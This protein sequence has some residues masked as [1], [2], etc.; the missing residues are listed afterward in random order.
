M[1]DAAIQGQFNFPTA[2]RI[3]AGCI[4]ELPSACR[5]L[6]I[7][8]P[9]VVTDAGISTLDWFAEI[10][11][12]LKRAALDFQVFS[13]IDANPSTHHVEAGQAALAA[14]HADGCILIGGGSAMDTGKCLALLADNPGGVLDYE[15]RDDNWVRAD[16]ARILPTLAVP[17]TAGT[18]SEVGRAAVIV[19]PTDQSKK[20]IFHPRLQPDR[21]LA[22]PELSYG[23]PPRL[24]A[25]TGMDALV[26]CRTSSKRSP[27][28][29]SIRASRGMRASMTC[30]LWIIT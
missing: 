19:D 9:L 23:L 15:D 26:H 20:I 14:H 17:T 18:G 13:E 1:S 22:D 11:V 16:A 4:R 2:Y 28:S 8:R 30:L 21:V 10:C 7:S 27:G 24:T 5:E 12:N 25:A 29:S 6:G 3:G